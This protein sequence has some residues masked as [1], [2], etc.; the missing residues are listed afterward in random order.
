[1]QLSY[2]CELCD[3]QVEKY[4]F[5]LQLSVLIIVYVYNIVFDEKKN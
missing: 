1:M 5:V 3:K 4:T 2:E